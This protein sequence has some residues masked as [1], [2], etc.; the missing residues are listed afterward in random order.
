MQNCLLYAVNDIK[1]I[2][3]RSCK[4]KN[5]RGFINV[6]VNHLAVNIISTLKQQLTLYQPY[7]NVEGR[8]CA[9]WVEAYQDTVS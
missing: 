1:L 5:L 9:G 2:Q 7:F 3:P 4:K 8:S 6:F